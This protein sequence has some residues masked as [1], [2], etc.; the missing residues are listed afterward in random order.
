MA[1]KAKKEIALSDRALAQAC[2]FRPQVR[3]ASAVYRF[4]KRFFDILLSAIAITILIPFLIIISIPAAIASKGKPFYADRR[5]GKDGKEIFVLKF[6]SM[7]ADAE[8]NAEKYLNEEQMQQWL[9][10][11][12]VEND[13]RVTK[14]G[15]FL[16]ATSIDELP[17]LFNIFVG[18]LSIVGPRP[19]TKREIDGSFFPD[20][21]VVLL[22]VR[23]GLIG[24][25]GVHGRSN[26]TYAS[27][28]RQRLELEYFEKR[29]FWFD[30]S[31]IFR[32]IPAVLKQDGAK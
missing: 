14:F 25:W 10:Y 20:Q 4:F 13:P 29:S 19:V 22:S 32:A 30:V 18:H 9:D 5:V 3:K 1:P 11:R 15:T 16:R 31:L 24:N 8:S 27:G 23:P 6:R 12:K 2:S 21:A 26:V 28:E 17:Q 7:V